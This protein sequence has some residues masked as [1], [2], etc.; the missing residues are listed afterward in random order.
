MFK[1]IFLAS[2]FNIGIITVGLGSLIVTSTW[3]AKI[4]IQCGGAFLVVNCAVIA[5]TVRCHV[6]SDAASWVVTFFKTTTGG[7]SRSTV[8]IVTWSFSSFLIVQL[9]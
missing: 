4:V 6:S 2:M 5:S 9:R 7:H 8:G 3:L 1:E